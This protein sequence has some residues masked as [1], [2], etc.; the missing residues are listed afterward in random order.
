MDNGISSVHPKPT[1]LVSSPATYPLRMNPPALLGLFY[2]N[3]STNFKNNY[4]LTFDDGPNLSAYSYVNADG[5]T[6][7]TTVVEQILDILKINSQ[8]AVFFICG[9]NLVDQAGNPIPGVKEILERIIAE[10]H[11]L[12]NHSFHHDNLKLG[13]YNH[14]QQD[15]PNIIAELTLNDETL[16]AVLGYHYDMKYFRPPYAEAGRTAKVDIAVAT[17]HKEMVILQL[18]SFDWRINGKSWTKA[19]SLQHV[20]NKLHSA[21]FSGGTV[22]MHELKLTTE[23]LPTVI[24]LF[25][26]TTNIHGAYTNHTLDDLFLIKYPGL[27]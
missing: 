1:N 17:M 6:I 20:S 21:T 15:V 26:T 22:L 24:H 5:Q 8:K 18:D 27:F 9:K 2:F 11:T 23:I 14:G 25:E 3:E 16:D 19:D 4:T 12:A 7:H 10:G 13:K